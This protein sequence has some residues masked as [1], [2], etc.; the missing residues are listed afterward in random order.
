[1]M[2]PSQIK[3]F[4]KSPSGKLYLAPEEVHSN[5]NFSNL[6][7][8]EVHHIGLQQ[9]LG[10]ISETN[11]KISFKPVSIQLSYHGDMSLRHWFC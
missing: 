4:S 1:M 5:A 2:M 10:N 8:P 6:T 3:S 7:P 11:Y 9:I